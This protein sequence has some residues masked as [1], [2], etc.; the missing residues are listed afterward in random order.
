MCLAAFLFANVQQQGLYTERK[1]YKQQKEEADRFKALQEELA[2]L[3]REHILWQLFHINE[4]GQCPCACC[5]RV[6]V[7]VVCACVCVLSA[8]CVCLCVF[9]CVCGSLIL[10]T[11]P[12]FSN[13]ID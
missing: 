4:G 3:K 12:L 9:V 6:C 5:L 7:R 11:P 10:S 13:C 8:C 1:Q 2:A